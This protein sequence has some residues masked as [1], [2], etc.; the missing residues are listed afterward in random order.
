MVP[1]GARPAGGI[2]QTRRRTLE[3]AIE[4]RTRQR[5]DAEGPYA[6]RGRTRICPAATHVGRG[7]EKTSE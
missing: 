6:S 2:G 4:L 5:S 7:Q 3:R 1:L